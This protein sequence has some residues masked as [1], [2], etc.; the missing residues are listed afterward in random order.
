MQIILYFQICF[1]IIRTTYVLERERERVRASLLLLYPCC[2]PTRDARLLAYVAQCG[3]NTRNT[4]QEWNVT[5]Q[6]CSM[7]AHWSVTARSVHY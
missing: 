7:S 5:G 1:C 2:S 3:T 6:W 4:T